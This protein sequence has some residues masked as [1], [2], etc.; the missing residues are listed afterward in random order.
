MFINV[1]FGK[2]F[3]F[4]SVCHL[5]VCNTGCKTKLSKIPTSLARERDLL[6][7]RIPLIHPTKNKTTIFSQS[8]IEVNFQPKIFEMNLQQTYGGGQGR[9]Q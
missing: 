3:N 2:I 7:M 5:S 8:D 1:G 9:I 6:H 4:V